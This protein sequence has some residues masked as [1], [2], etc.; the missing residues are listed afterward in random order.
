MTTAADGSHW[1]GGWYIVPSTG[2][3]ETII[4][5]AV[6]GKWSIT[7]TPDLSA[8]QGDNGFAGLAAVPGGGIWAVGIRTNSAGNPATLIEHHN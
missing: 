8:D 5:H 6:N 7:P 3:H 4:E 1:A 2:N